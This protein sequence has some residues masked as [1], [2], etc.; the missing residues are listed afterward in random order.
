MGFSLNCNLHGMEYRGVRAGISKSTGKPW[1]SLV[2]EDS[3]AQ[4][5]EVS[6]PADLQGDVYSLGLRKGDYINI[7]V[8]AVAY[9][10]SKDRPGNSYIQLTDVPVL[11][12]DSDGVVE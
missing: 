7:D 12:A 8:R 11:V 10:G 5:V 9:D 2:L 4:Q 1:M 6:V 3:D